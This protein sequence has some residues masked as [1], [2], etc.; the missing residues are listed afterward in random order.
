[1]NNSDGTVSLQLTSGTSGA[2]GTLAVT[3]SL[4][5]PAT[6]LAYTSTVTGSNANLTVDGVNLTSASNTVTNLIPGVTFQLLAPSA[7]GVR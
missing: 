6:A 1:M 3:S 7:R 5:D 4:V 2:T